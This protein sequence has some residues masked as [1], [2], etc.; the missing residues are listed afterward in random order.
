MIK[1]NS[2]NSENIPY[3]CH[4]FKK[5]CIYFRENENFS[6][7][8]MPFLESFAN[9]NGKCVS[10]E[11]FFKNNIEVKKMTGVS[12]SGIVPGVEIQITINHV[13]LAGFLS[14]QPRFAP[15][16]EQAVR[17]KVAEWWKIVQEVQEAHQN[18]PTETSALIDTMMQVETR[19]KAHIQE[20]FDV[21]IADNVEQTIQKSVQGAVRDTVGDAVSNSVRTAITTPYEAIQR[22]VMDS[23]VVMGSIRAD[24]ADIKMGVNRIGAV[25]TSKD[26]GIEAEDKIYDEL[27]CAL[28]SDCE[29]QFTR[30]VPNEGDMIIKRSGFTDIL[31]EV[32]NH[33]SNVNKDHVER[34]ETDVQQKKCHGII[35]SVRSG[36]VGRSKGLAIKPNIHNK[37]CVYIAHNHYDPYTIRDFVRFLHRVDEINLA[38]NSTRFT[39][40]IINTITSRLNNESSNI[41]RMKN[42]AQDMLDTAKAM[43]IDIDSVLNLMKDPVEKRWIGKCSGCGQKFDS[44]S[45]K[46]FIGHINNPNYPKCKDAAFIHES[47]SSA[48]ASTSEPKK[49]GRTPKTLNTIKI[50]R[51]SKESSPSSTAPSSPREGDAN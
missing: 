11:K 38:N 25:K 26:I 47:S 10:L 16:L 51:V 50:Q 17:L 37:W 48:Q 2:L 29:V 15:L 22:A 42:L 28:D 39:P 31:L 33:V 23:A 43:S 12:L 4:I 44:E 20:M 46:G 13:Q 7:R 1:K 27:T 6:R 34:F 3:F 18:E 41:R 5:E 14:K 21:G 24:T 40:A 49:R 35:V 9:S 19:L 45:D 8:K 36:F 30:H 32:K